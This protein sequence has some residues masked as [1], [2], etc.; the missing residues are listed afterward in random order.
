M[1]AIYPATYHD[2]QGEEATTIANDGKTLR[3]V[4]R[5]VEFTGESFDF[6]EHC[7]DPGDPALASFSLH[8]RDLCSC[9]IECDMPMQ[10]AVGN[11]TLDSNLHMRLDLGDPRPGGDRGIDREELLLNLTI[12]GKSFSSCG[13]H[14]WFENELLEI[15]AALPG[16]MYMKCCTTCAFSDYSPYGN[17]MF[18]CMACFRDNN[19]AYRAV[20]GKASLF[21]IWDTLSGFVQETY[22]CPEYERRKPGSGYRG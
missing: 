5:G 15:Q 1:R 8:G 6:F 7:L 3:M 9:V 17:G 4:V 22:L 14:G 21:A 13:Q 2:R 10:V 18:G 11:E 19:A 20:K 16:G 12:A